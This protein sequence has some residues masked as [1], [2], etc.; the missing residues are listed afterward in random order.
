MAG[1]RSDD[2]TLNDD[3]QPSITSS[4]EVLRE[5]DLAAGIT[6]AEVVV[7]PPADAID[8]EVRKARADVATEDVVAEL[9]PVGEGTDA[10]VAADQEAAEEAGDF[11]SGNYEDRTAEQLRAL[12]ASRG[13]ATGGSK[14]DLIDRLRG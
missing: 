14:A 7:R 13:L 5:A 3:S 1:H 2:P 6:P 4:A 12:A 9:Q 8:M 11:G 10:G